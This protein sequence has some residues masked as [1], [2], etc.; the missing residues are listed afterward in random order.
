MAKLFYPAIALMNHLRYAQKFI[1]ISLLFTA[2]LLLLL[3]LLVSELDTNT[4][5][6]YTEL[7][8]VRY[9]RELR[10]LREH[11][12]ELQLREHMYASGITPTLGEL[13]KTQSQVEADF[14]TLTAIDQVLGAKFETSEQFKALAPTYTTIRQRLDNHQYAS[15]PTTIGTIGSSDDTYVQLEKQ[16]QTLM[17]Q[18]GDRSSLVL[19]PDLVT[20]FTINN[21]LDKLPN[22]QNLLAQTRA[23]GQAITNR[24]IIT[25]GER[26]QLL[27]QVGLLKANSEELKRN[28]DI[29]FK[30]K[31]DLKVELTDPLNATLVA[32]TQLLDQIQQEITGTTLL[33]LKPDAYTATANNAIAAAFNLWNQTASSVDKL[34]NERQAS[35]SQKKI[36]TIGMALVILLLVSYFLVGFYLSVRRT[37]THLDEASQRMIAGNTTE[38]FL[39][40]DNKDEL[41]QVVM[42]FNKIALALVSTST[43]LQLRQNSSETISQQI[44]ALATEL[45]LSANQQ[46]SAN[47]QQL[48]TVSEVNTAAKASFLAAEQVAQLTQQIS[49]TVNQATTASEQ[50]K[51]TTSRAAQQSERGLQAVS[52]TVAQSREGE[53]F[54]KHLLETMQ[55]L[56]AK[57]N[58][59]RRI[60]ELISGIATETHLL[61]LNASIEA[62]GAGVYGERFNVIAQEVKSLATRSATASR[63]VVKV[64]QEIENGLHLTMELAADSYL[65][66]QGTA[67]K[68]NLAG[69][70]IENLLDISIQSQTQAE[71][72][73]QATGQIHELTKLIA[74]AAVAQRFTSEHLLAGFSG[75]NLVAQRN[76]ESGQLVSTTALSLERV[77]HTLTTVLEPVVV[78]V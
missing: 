42:S 46:A 20:Y 56:N 1:L 57:G 9:L 2:P 26:S 68:A 30:L 11:V 71:S 12:P 32:T 41:G 78:G 23:L 47:A 55:E 75:L 10:L 22:A 36:L 49:E 34:L 28:L 63:E 44:L 60:L 17:T 7:D 77:S 15:W 50:I 62:A 24:K 19:D 61:A 25:Q 33:K 6:V 21:I 54:Y 74:D 39:Q 48:A 31:P 53:S 35:F 72:I 52:E 8:G 40:F 67:D 5:V 18:I 38:Q 66:A 27:V 64:I 65:K 45:K 37:V 16:I 69:D 70:V 58:S 73:G 14:N 43:Q 3:V 59:T 29:A 13:S 51:V 4:N 76:V